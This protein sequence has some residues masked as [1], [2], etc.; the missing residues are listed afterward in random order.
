[1]LD[2]WMPEDHS[3]VASLIVEDKRRPIGFQT[4]VFEARAGRAFTQVGA[5]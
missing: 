5:P 2:S 1:M 4:E 3:I